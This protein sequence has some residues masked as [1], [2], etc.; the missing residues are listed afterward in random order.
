MDYKKLFLTEDYE[1]FDGQGME[2]PTNVSPEELGSD[3]EVWGQNNPD[4]VNDQDLNGQFD[5]EGLPADMS[6]EYVSKI[7]NWKGTIENVS[8]ELTEVY[9]F[10]TENADK[11]GA[12]EIFNTIGSEVEKIVTDLGTLNGHLNTLGNKIKLAMKRD[13]AK[14]SKK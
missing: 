13:S 1:D 8:G 14:E 2:E 5:V 6:E 12:G 7:Q 4:I 10:A 11:A 3:D 9:A